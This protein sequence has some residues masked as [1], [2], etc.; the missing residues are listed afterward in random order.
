MK[1]LA[2]IP[3][4]LG[5]SRL[6]HKP[7]ADIHGKPM[8]QHVWEKTRAAGN[9]DEVIIATDSSEIIDAAIAFGANAM[10][11]SKDCASGTDRVIEVAREIP[12]DL[13]INVQGDEPLLESSDLDALVAAMRKNASISVGT[14]C[15]FISDRQAC[16]PNLVKVVLDAANNALY[17]S[18]ARIPYP[19]DQRESVW[20]GHIGVYAY[21]PSALAAFSCLPVSPLENIEKLEQLRFL[22]AGISIHCVMARKMTCGV[23]TQED[24]EWARYE[25]ASKK[26]GSAPE[27]RASLAAIRLI[28]SDVDGTLTD[29]SLYFDGSGETIKRFNARDGMGVRL[30]QAKGLKI[31]ILTGRD[32]SA[33]RARLAEMGIDH[34]ELGV[35]EK[36]SG[37]QRLM[38]TLGMTPDSVLFIGDDLQDLPAFACCGLAVAP[39][40]G[41][42]EVKAKA[43]IV[44][45]TSGGHGVL[46]EVIDLVLQ[47]KA[48]QAS[49]IGINH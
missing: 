7:L 43:D 8:V 40:D 49:S 32:S 42:T 4:R 26:E 23:D 25:L 29:G 10:L 24:L 22:Q 19:R 48:E 35:Q 21:Q 3:A 39:A 30:A 11:T 15:A 12:A 28:I 14:L 9:I 46:R 27:K 1:T 20:H 34:F 38:A 5:S 2:I 31:A 47:A 37:C 17:F 36:A 13:Y 44:T 6:P 18:R 16:D 41:M 33:L 45:E